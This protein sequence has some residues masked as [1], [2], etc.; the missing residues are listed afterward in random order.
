MRTLYILLFILPTLVFSQQEAS[1]WYFGGNAGIKFHTDGSITPLTNGQLNTSEGCATLSDSNGNLLFY[2]DGATVWNK[3]HAIMAN[4]SGLMGN[5][6]STQSAT[7][8]PKPGSTTL[9]YVFTLDYEVHPNG[10]RYSII[11]MSLNNGIGGVTTNKNIL[12]YTPSDEKLSIVKHTNGTDFWVVTHGW[13]SN[14]FYSYLLTASGLSAMPVLSNCGSV[15]TGSHDNVWGYM[16]ISPDG[17]KLGIAHTPINFELMDFDANTGIVSNPLTLFSLN[18]AYGVEFSP[19]SQVLYASLIGNPVYKIIQFDLTASNVLNSAQYVYSASI[20]PLALQLGPDNKIYFAEYNQPKLGVI[21][22][23]NTIGLGCNAQINAIDLAGRKCKYGLPPFIVSYFNASFT[24]VN[25]CLGASTQF[26]IDSN[27]TVTSAL[28]DFGDGTTATLVNPTHQYAMAGNYTVSITATTANG[29]STKSKQITISEVPVVANTISNSIVCGTA[30]RSYDLSQFNTTLLGGQSNSIYGVAYFSTLANATNHTTILANTV[31]LPLGATTYYAKVYNLANTSCN[32]IT[33]FTITLLQQPVAHL[34][35]D[36]V[37]CENLPYNGIETFDLSSQN[38]TVLGTQNASNYNITYHT[39]QNDADTG[40]NDLPLLYTNTLATET[41]YARIENNLNSSC[42]DTVSFQ[43]KVI[44]QP[45]VSA[46]TDF[47]ICDDTSNDGIAPFDLSLKTLEV[48]NGQ[49]TSIFE[50]RYYNSLLEAQNGTNFITVPINNTTN[51][52]TVYYSISAI[53]NSSCKAIASFKL[54]VSSLPIA[55]TVNGIFICDDVSNDGLGLFQLQNNSAA[56]LGNQ[57]T[58]QFILSYHRTPN[59]ANSNNNP[60][61]LNYSNSSNPQTIYVRL[62]NNLNTSCFATTS[63]QIGLYKMPVAHQPQN[64]FLCDDVTNDGKESFDLSSQKAMILA[65]QS[66]TDYLVSYHLLQT[67]ADLGINSLPNNY[68]NTSNPQI[69]FARIANVLSPTCFDTKSFQLEVKPKPNLIMD[70][71]FSICEGKSI[72]I[73]AP[74]GFDTYLWS[75]GATTVATS[76]MQANNYSVTVTKNYGTITCD[77]IKNIIV[78]QSNIAKITTIDTQDWTE[79]ENMISVHVTGDGVYEYS[80]DGVNYQNS[81]D[82]YGLSSG[83]FTVY[84]NDKKGCGITKEEVYLLLYP[85]FFTP[86]G[87]GINDTWKIKFSIIEPDMKLQIYDRYGKLLSSFKGF[88]LG[89]DG[90]LNGVILPSDDY[91]FV[92][93]RSNGKQ[94]R[95]HFAMK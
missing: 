87:D 91:W 25:L 78:Y 15:V 49:S 13:N 38:A 20:A 48:L 2:T 60:L 37:I 66:A 54:L 75:N 70:D 22:S 74:T 31:S 42:F 6:S 92:V 63:F 7:I 81:P 35:T 95:G 18:G 27:A 77:A 16:K 46:V 72:T 4:G 79:N 33:S 40:N 44:Q 53:G 47:K 30:G 52:Q 9:F 29:T 8:V 59:D 71:T 88:D 45:T 10:F 85:K 43:I 58:S 61:A 73:S 41:L 82:F 57:N 84:V 5:W 68:S 1:V 62:E 11:D 14:T 23:P 83:S 64:L 19:N 65:G 21:N 90:S 94:Y 24:A 69:I 28:W 50:V 67:D 56:I 12:I 17:T 51:N 39:S 55:N 89:W 76:V 26:S 80:L 93:E 34:P 3:N 32:A 86:N 36:Y